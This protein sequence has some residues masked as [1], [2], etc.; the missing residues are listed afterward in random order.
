MDRSDIPMPSVA[1][2]A[3]G[4]NGNADPPIETAGDSADRPA[5]PT[6]S[7]RHRRWRMVGAL[8]TAGDFDAPWVNPRNVIA[9]Q[10]I[11]TGRFVF[12]G[13]RRPDA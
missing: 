2:L 13:V 3:P 5:W 10:T 8:R 7:A 9:T 12:P 1:A 11:R 6:G 4:A